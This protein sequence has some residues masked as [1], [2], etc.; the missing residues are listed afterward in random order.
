M[1]ELIRLRQ[2]CGGTRSLHIRVDSGHAGDAVSDLDQACPLFLSSLITPENDDAWA[3]HFDIERHAGN[4]RVLLHRGL[5]RNCQRMLLEAHL[6]LDL[7]RTNHVGRNFERAVVLTPRTNDSREAHRAALGGDGHV[8]AAGR[9]VY[10]QPRAHVVLD[11]GVAAG[12]GGGDDR[13]CEER[14]RRNDGADESRQGDASILTPEEP[15]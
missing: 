12:A 14:C 8:H 6:V 3:G 7:I 2:A 5:N 10:D 13:E 15:R 11:V 4:E 9:V 1:R